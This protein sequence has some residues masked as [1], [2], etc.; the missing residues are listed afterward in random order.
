M[1]SSGVS[2]DSYT[3][4]TYIKFKKIFQESV[5]PVYK[6]DKKKSPWEDDIKMTSGI[7]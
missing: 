6:V 5:F 4:L 3:V 2:K 1:P 7:Q